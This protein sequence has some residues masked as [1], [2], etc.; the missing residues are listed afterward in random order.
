MPEPFPSVKLPCSDTLVNSK[1]TLLYKSTGLVART[2]LY[3][4][5]TRSLAFEWGADWNFTRN[6]TGER[7]GKWE[8]T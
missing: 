5:K 6:G 3:H 8:K 7:E 1:T 2:S 4:F